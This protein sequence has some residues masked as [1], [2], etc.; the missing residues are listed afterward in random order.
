MASLTAPEIDRIRRRLTSLH[1]A[2][3]SWQKVADATGL[4]KGEAH[5]IGARGHVPQDKRI[6]A[7]LTGESI[8]DV[9]LQRRGSNG[10]FRPRK[11]PQ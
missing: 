10:R 5:A 3:G 7:L 6:I 4:T 1:D 8:P 9:V 11:A 2:L